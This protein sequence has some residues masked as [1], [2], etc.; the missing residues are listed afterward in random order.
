MDS[1]G[2]K[3]DAIRLYTDINRMTASGD[4]TGLRHVSLYT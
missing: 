4:R 2:F 1:K 3:K